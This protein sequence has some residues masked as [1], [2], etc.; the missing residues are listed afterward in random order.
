MF[1]PTRKFLI[2]APGLEGVSAPEERAGISFKAH[3]LRTAFLSKRL[4]LS[5]AQQITSMHQAGAHISW[6]TGL[7]T[8]IVNLF[9]LLYKRSPQMSFESGWT[10]RKIPKEE[11]HGI[12]CSL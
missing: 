11:I 7:F 6:C 8:P 3:S 2:A 4:N 12:V 1:G 10:G 5:C 9:H